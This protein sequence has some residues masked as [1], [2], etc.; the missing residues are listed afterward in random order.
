M[1][2]VF[3][4]LCFIAIISSPF[5]GVY[6]A[7]THKPNGVQLEYAS[8]EEKTSRDNNFGITVALVW[9]LPA[10]L[11]CILMY[12]GSR[13]DPSTDRPCLAEIFVV[14]ALV[15]PMAWVTAVMGAGSYLEP[16][17]P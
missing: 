9:W 6:Y 15:W 1:R 11:T 12:A 7:V 8:K 2:T 5:L 3:L 14:C 16:P 10:L 17:G 13:S 4:L